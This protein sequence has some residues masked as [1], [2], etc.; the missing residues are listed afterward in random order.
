MI[1]ASGD[2]THREIPADRSRPMREDRRRG[3]GF[4]AL[5]V[6]AYLGHGLTDNP[7]TAVVPVMHQ[8]QEV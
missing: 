8:K 4:S 7:R 2:G 6:Q 3:T 5:T 1:E